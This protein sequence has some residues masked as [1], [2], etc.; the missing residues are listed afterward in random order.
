MPRLTG[1]HSKGGWGDGRSGGNAEAAGSE[2]D[3]CRGMGS[4]PLTEIEDAE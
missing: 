4:A 1:C 2:D 3:L